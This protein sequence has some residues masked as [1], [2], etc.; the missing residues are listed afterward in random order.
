LAT[1][2]PY[3]GLRSFNRDESDLFFGRDTCV[4]QMVQ[5]LA[6]TRFLAVLGTSGSGKSSLV[7]TGL[8]DALELGLHPAGPAW[9]ICEFSPAGDP[10]GNLTTALLAEWAGPRVREAQELLDSFLRRGPAS[11]V[12][13]ANDGN[14]ATGTNLLLL[15]DQFEEIFRFDTYSEREDTEAF[16]KILICSAEATTAN[17]HVVITM[18]SE[19]IGACALIPGLAEKINQGLYLVPRMTRSECEAAIVGPAK[20]TGFQ[21]EP[22]L[23]THVL[24][25]MESFAPWSDDQDMDPVSRI[26]RRADQLPVMQHV[27]NRM[28]RRAQ[29]GPSGQVLTL[30]NYERLGGVSGALNA[31]G[32]ELLASAGTERQSVAE[33]IFRALVAGDS[34]T[35]A[36]RRPLPLREILASTGAPYDD[37]VAVL[38]IFRSNDANFLRP[39]LAERLTDRTVIEIAHESLIRQWSMLT[40]WVAREARSAESWRLLVSYAARK[41]RGEEEFPHGLGLAALERWW[42]TDNPKPGWAA[43]YGGDFTAVAA[44]LDQSIAAEQQRRDA[45]LERE[46]REKERWQEALDT[47]ARNFGTNKDVNTAAKLIFIEDIET[48]STQAPRDQSPDRDLLSRNA[49][50]LISNARMLTEVGYLEQASRRAEMAHD[51]LFPD[52]DP[53][54]PGVT[55]TLKAKAKLA[56]AEAHWHHRAIG[57]SQTALD[58]AKRNVA[59]VDESGWEEAVLSA[60]MGALQASLYQ[61]QDRYHD[62]IVTIERTI[63]DANGFV[64]GG[65]AAPLVQRQALDEVVARLY[66]L[67]VDALERVGLDRGTL[68]ADAEAFVTTRVTNIDRSG[69]NYLPAMLQALLDSHRAEY[70]SEQ[71]AHQLALSHADDAVNALDRVCARDWQN[72]DCRRELARTLL[73]RAQITYGLDPLQA[74]A[75]VASARAIAYHTKI[76]DSSPATALRI[77][78]WSDYIS[79]LVAEVQNHPEVALGEHR[80]ISRRL[81]LFS[82]LIQQEDL[83]RWFG[84]HEIWT[85]MVKPDLDSRRVDEILNLV[86]RTLALY[87]TDPEP[88]EDKIYAAQQRYWALARLLNWSPKLVGEEEWNR[89]FESVMRDTSYLAAATAETTSWLLSKGYWQ[90]V[91]AAY[92]RDEV[93]DPRSAANTLLDAVGNCISVMRTPSSFV[94]AARAGIEHLHGALKLLP[95]SMIG[96]RTMVLLTEYIDAVAEPP[97]GAAAGVLREELLTTLIATVAETHGKLKPGADADTSL[98]AALEKQQHRLALL[99][100][101]AKG[102]S[103]APGGNPGFDFKELNLGDKGALEAV[104][105]K[106]GA[107]INWS[108]PPLFAAAWR[109]LLDHEREE[110][111]AHF[112]SAGALTRRDIRQFVVRVR[113]ATV[114]FYDGGQLFD[115]EVAFETGPRVFS[116][117]SVRGGSTCVLE[118]KS[119]PIHRINAT[120]ALLLD[121]P[122]RV[123]GYLRFFCSYVTG[124]QGSFQVVEHVTDL[125]WDSTADQSIRDRVARVL[126]PLVVWQEKKKEEGANGTPWNATATIQYSDD[127]FFAKF[128]IRTDGLVQM[129]DDQPIETR[130]PINPIRVT[131]GG[132]AKPVKRIAAITQGIAIFKNDTAFLKHLLTLPTNRRPKSFDWLVKEALALS[133]ANPDD[134][135]GLSAAGRVLIETGTQLSRGVELAERAH[136]LTPE[137]P[138]I[139]ETVAWGYAKSGRLSEAIALFTK[140]IPLFEKG[141][142]KGTAAAEADAHLA[143]AY[144]HLGQAYRLSG[145]VT[146]ARTAFD[147]ARSR[148]ASSEVKAFIDGELQLLQTESDA[149]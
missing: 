80:R 149:L 135:E 41:A 31:H 14:L 57:K 113:S 60:R 62:Q 7:K 119:P 144:A 146:E 65:K 124:E 128:E 123:A 4:D 49:E 101:N 71:G 33:K 32:E 116:L 11:V 130:L 42:N 69:S 90:G 89:S 26:S 5:R 110:A 21:I 82:E 122:N 27:L 127:L 85:S 24:N 125:L 132:R 137:N 88:T 72:L 115:A 48:R 108:A 111:L 6:D 91:K 15:V 109:T 13:W 121:T 54:L 117:L 129:L 142:Q 56:A 38:D 74:A 136:T 18:R 133:T 81:K 36:T 87:A 67:W 47:T 39:S 75:D 34:P 103:D 139:M 63:A 44:F 98:L 114:D 12:E 46:R 120:G 104:R 105:R 78:I 35:S 30:E 68:L 97:A 16:A 22:R 53:E 76:D 93:K 59:Q 37:V 23:V 86:K 118:G 29:D 52:G 143:H 43:R 45:E 28:A 147:A 64:T 9:R 61:A 100:G 77:D 145:N 70:L 3:P 1:R 51:L 102:A 84:A 19:Y 138:N 94:Q 141:D 95:E 112:V 40:N 148:R 96:D 20:V 79:T 92:L 106:G 73:R 131:A 10:F 50:L 107:R 134:A 140:A 2:F 58:E 25:D 8:L 55:R 126:R 83:T 99:D 66:I 17:I